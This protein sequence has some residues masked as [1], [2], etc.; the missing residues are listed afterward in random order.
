LK[1]ALNFEEMK[2]KFGGGD[3]PSDEIPHLQSSI[4]DKLNEV[5]RA[6]DLS[7][8]LGGVG[9]KLGGFF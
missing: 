9:K 4:E 2:K 7:G 6:V 5:K 1:N 3:L 8:N